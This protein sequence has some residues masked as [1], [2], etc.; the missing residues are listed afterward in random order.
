MLP[1]TLC[2]QRA[3]GSGGSPM[4]NQCPEKI[5]ETGLGRVLEGTETWLCKLD[6]EKWE[7][8]SLL[9]KAH[10]Q[11]RLHIVQ[12]ACIHS[13]GSGHLDRNLNLPEFGSVHGENH[14]V[15]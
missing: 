13:T 10:V 15:V 1:A 8:I 7:V 6:S 4:A 9:G 11:F 14:Q 3:R 5:S 12:H 2:F